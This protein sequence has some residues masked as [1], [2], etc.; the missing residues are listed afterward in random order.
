MENLSSIR[1]K[2]IAT[3]MLFIIFPLVFVFAFAMHP[4]LLHPRLLNAEGLILR[5]RQN[6]LLQFG[7]VLVTFNA[8]LLVGAAV[9]FMTLLRRTSAAWAGF[10][11][12]IIA[13]LGAI[14]L[15]ADKGAFCLTM[16]AFDTLSQKEFAQSMPAVL[17]IFN[18]EGWMMITM[19]IILL[20]VGFAIQAVGLFVTRSFPRLASLFF[21]TGVTLVGF[22][23]GFEIINLSASILMAIALLPYGLRLIFRPDV[24]AR[25]EDRRVA[26]HASTPIN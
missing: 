25:K 3:G 21:L 6:D 4:D 2:N 23:D 17:A 1:I 15:A 5:A 7:H 16:S 11:G 9:H 18:K 20:P 10:L 24:V 13:I 14:L 8:A 12:G 26:A 19:G 22:P